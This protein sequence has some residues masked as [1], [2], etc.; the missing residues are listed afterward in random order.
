[1]EPGHPGRDTGPAAPA[2]GYSGDLK[3]TFKG[4]PVTITSKLF[5]SNEGGGSVNA[6][7]MYFESSI[8]L[9]GKKLAEFV[10]KVAEGEMKREYEYI[11]DALNAANK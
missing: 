8:P 6:M 5:L 7:T 3:I 9:I 10:G 4:V 1:M 2:K 11:R